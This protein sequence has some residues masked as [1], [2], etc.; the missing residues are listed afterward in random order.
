MTIQKSAEDYLE[1]ILRLNEE[2]GYA[3]SVDIADE[4]SFSK[5]SVSIA[6]KHLREDDY[7]T[8]DDDNLI[9][10]TAKGYDIANKI[11]GR[12]KILKSA[13][14]EIGVSEETAEK[15]ACLIE[16]YISDETETALMKAMNK[17][18]VQDS[19]SDKSL[20]SAM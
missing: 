16:H 15:D 18:S 8:M 5:P 1:V 12:H 11:Y 10:L 4:L 7:I 2:K 20:C 6:M 14:I 13:L 3:R 19:E 9:H 17:N